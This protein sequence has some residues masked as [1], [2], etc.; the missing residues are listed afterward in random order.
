[1]HVAVTMQSLHEKQH[2]VCHRDSRMRNNWCTAV[3]LPVDMTHAVQEKQPV[4]CHRDGKMRNGVVYSVL[5][6]G[7][8]FLAVVNT[9]TA[10]PTSHQEP[11]DSLASFQ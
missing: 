9:S 7:L 8:Q 5:K 4:V 11:G 1:M 10:Y 2:V 6:D 3:L